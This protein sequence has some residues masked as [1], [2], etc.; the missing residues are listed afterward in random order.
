M[1]HTD[2]VNLLRD[3][4]LEG[5]G[6]WADFGSGTGA[7]TLALADLLGPDGIIHSIDKDANALRAQADEMHR[8]FPATTLTTHAQ[9]YTHSINLP[10]LGGIV[11]ANTLHFHRDALRVVNLIKS[12][13]KVD[14]RMIVVEYNIDAGNY[15]V[16]HPIS[17]VR[18]QRLATDA[19]FAHTQLL[20]T[21]PSRFLSGIYSAVSW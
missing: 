13:L 4:I 8:R 11:A 3:G 20:M 9:D 6:T 17:F 2:H 21:R 12:Y 18:W 16:P 14:G 7:F 15:A 1:N 5:Y 10:K 19:G